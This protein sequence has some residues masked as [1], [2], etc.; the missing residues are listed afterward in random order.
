MTVAKRVF[1]TANGELSAALEAAGMP[2]KRLLGGIFGAEI[3][4]AKLGLVGEIKKVFAQ[5]VND[6]INAGKIPVLT[7]I[8]I[9]STQQ[10]LN[11]NA[12]VAARELAIALQPLKVVFISAG[13]GW[14]EDG[15][16]VSEVNMAADYD[17]M[18]N[19]DYTGRQGTLLKLKEMKQIID[20]LP[21]VSSVTIASASALASQLLPHAGPGTQIRKGQKVYKVLSVGSTDSTRLEALLRSGNDTAGINFIHQNGVSTNPHVGS[22]SSIFFSEEYGAVAIITQPTEKNSVP[23]LHSFVVSPIA[24]AEGVETALWN[25]IREHYPSLSW[26]GLPSKDTTTA[27]T[28]VNTHGPARIPI[29]FPALS[30]TRSTPHATGYNRL[31]NAGAAMWYGKLTTE[32]LSTTT[33][34]IENFQSTNYPSTTTNVQ[35]TSNNKSS[36]VTKSSKTVRVG[37]LGARGFVGRELLKLIANHPNMSVVCASSRAL[38]GQ[39]VPEGLGV[40]EANDACISG[41]KFSDVGPEQLKRGDHPEVDAWVLA[42]PNGLAATHSEAIDHYI[43]TNKL[44]N[45]LQ[46]DLSADMRFDTT[47]KWTYGLPERHNARDLI[48]KAKKISNPGCY[49]TGSQVALMPLLDLYRKND[50]FAWDP[51]AKPHI[52]GVSGYSGA[53]TSPSDK[54]DP[55]KLRDNLLPYSLVGH[56]H[57][58]EVGFHCGVP[59]AFMPHVAPFFQG[60][61]LTVSGHI[62]TKTNTPLNNITIAQIREAYEKYYKNERLIRVLTGD[63]EMPDV[64]SHGT[65]YHGVTVGGFTYDAKTGRIALVSCIDNLLKGAATQAIQNMNLAL[66]LDEY[67]GIP[68]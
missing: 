17:R 34:I 44:T 23:F 38:V 30:I 24:L 21:A 11:I 65:Y 31:V 9:S 55:N 54:N 22:V 48:R 10:V 62:K 46:I 40:P 33:K 45:P 61:S 28:D 64:R 32:Q 29:N 39:S 37:L 57:E 49:S 63:K 27:V 67:A 20:K 26:Y 18:V 42:L 4:D 52:F 35:V 53:G 5:E 6:A 59:V 51:T 14:K 68:L 7:S 3:A 41:L 50:S 60:I 56:I 47:G 16:V 13:G 15:V 1:E 43:Q 25:T 66:G 36:K 2:T 58:R 12:D 8:G 19:R